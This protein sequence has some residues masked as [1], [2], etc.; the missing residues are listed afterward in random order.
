IMFNL[1]SMETTPELQKTIKNASAKLTE[2]RNDISLN[3]KLYKRVESVF[4]TR[5][6]LMLEPESDM[7]LEKSYKGF[8]R[9][10]AKLS[11]E[12]K[13]VLR[14]INKHQSELGLKFG[15]N[16]LNETNQF[17]K[18]VTDKEELAGL[19]DFVLKSAAEAAAK[20]GKEGWKFTIH[21]PSY[22]PLIQYADN[23]DL[24]KEM[25][26]AYNSRAF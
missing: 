18:Y 14:D 11:E 17:A 24:R 3:D 25:F 4:N 10:G 9:N 1:N 22:V 6:S 13:N 12:N 5:K 20:D 15:E 19:P 16:V 7:L 2:Y 8:V 23:R 26:M 21:A